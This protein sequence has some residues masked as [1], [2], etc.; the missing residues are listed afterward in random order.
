MFA[1]TFNEVVRHTRART[2]LLNIVLEC[3]RIVDVMLPRNLAQGGLAEIDETMR[4]GK[5]GDL[6]LVLQS[7][8]IP[9]AKV[10]D[11]FMDTLPKECLPP[12]NAYCNRFGGKGPIDLVNGLQELSR[13]LDKVCRGIRI[14]LLMRD[15]DVEPRPGRFS[16]TL[17]DHAKQERPTTVA[18]VTAVP[19][20]NPVLQ[21]YM[22]VITVQRPSRS[23]MELLLTKDLSAV[24]AA[25]HIGGVAQTAKQ[26]A[27]ACAD[28]LVGL[29]A[30]TA[31][32][33]L[34]LHL[35]SV[36]QEVKDAPNIC[37]LDPRTLCDEKARLLNRAG[38]MTLVSDRVTEDDIGGL[39]V[40]KKWLRLR[41]R[42]F[43]KEATE[44]KMRF[45]RGMMMVGPPGTAKSMCSKLVAHTFGMPLIRLDMGA[46]FN[47]YVGSSER[48]MRNALDVATATAPCVLML[49]EVDKSL[50]GMESGKSDSGTSSRI[51]G[52]LLTWIADKT[53]PVFVVMTAN[54]ILGLPP[55]MTRR[56][57]LDTVMF[58][59]LP[60]ITERKAIWD[61]HLRKVGQ[62]HDIDTVSLARLSEGYSG[63]E[64]EQAVQDAM[65]DVF[66]PG[67]SLK[68]NTKALENAMQDIVP[69]S[70]A[71]KDSLDGLRQWAKA[72]ALLASLPESAEASPPG[73]P[74][75]K[76]R[77]SVFVDV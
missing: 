38:Y 22:P 24:D 35:H 58:V 65:Y 61:I 40:L 1:E 23:E 50:A 20:E 26:A 51:L 46:L 53:A 67:K 60:T 19:I 30:P 15:V 77:Q 12:I 74:S 44:S 48:N 8:C 54:N 27:E 10:P 66:V 39:E 52:T 71:R 2:P 73:K 13:D 9:P 72:N 69:L 5:N 36:F 14:L 49:D 6:V 21:T 64:I 7:T 3:E 4:P 41:A 43:T 37:N 76:S 32:Q 45:P 31:C 68:L 33:I 63:A 29:H 18:L 25:L 59:D 56:G 57:R 70:K 55:E 17:L 62:L 75:A 34:S 28:A 42:G 16:R 11:I 47:Q